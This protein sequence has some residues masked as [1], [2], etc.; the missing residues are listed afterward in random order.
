M[1]DLVFWVPQALDSELVV[2]D[3]SGNVGRHFRWVAICCTHSAHITAWRHVV[4]T[5][6]GLTIIH[7]THSALVKTPSKSTPPAS[8]HIGHRYSS[9]TRYAS[10]AARGRLAE[11]THATV[12]PPR[13]P[14]LEQRCADVACVCGSGQCKTWHDPLR[15]RRSIRDR[16]CLT[17][18]PPGREI[19]L[20]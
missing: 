8:R 7:P 19:F 20:L 3:M 15:A 9:G 17:I 4:N 18:F 10:Q 13:T 1:Y 14:Q 11:Q 2:Y 6:Q 16:Q 5:T 12:S